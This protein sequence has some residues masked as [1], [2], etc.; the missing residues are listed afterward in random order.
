MWYKFI[1]LCS[2]LYINLITHTFVLKFATHEDVE[3]EE[4]NIF[5]YCDIQTYIHFNVL[6]Y[7][8]L[9]KTKVTYLSVFINIYVY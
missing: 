9:K 6:S 8:C 3:I 2:S 7:R 4:L 1:H 5:L